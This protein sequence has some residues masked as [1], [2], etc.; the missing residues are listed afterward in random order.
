[1]PLA[2]PVLEIFG[3]TPIETMHAFRKGLIETVTYLVLDNVPATELA[4]FDTLAV[5]FHQSHRQTIRKAYQ[6]TNFQQWHNQFVKHHSPQT[7]WI[8]VSICYSCTIR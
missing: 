1:V 8:G 3:A 7:L 6:S 2:D 5:R 4:V